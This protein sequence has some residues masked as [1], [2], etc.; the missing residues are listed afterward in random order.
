MPPCHG[1][2]EELAG[3]A[4][5]QQSCIFPVKRQLSQQS[6]AARTLRQAK[7]STETFTSLPAP[8]TPIQQVQRSRKP[9]GNDGNGSLANAL[10]WSR[11]QTIPLPEESGAKAARAKSR[12]LHGQR[13]KTQ[14][15]C[16]GASRGCSAGTATP[17]HSNPPRSAPGASPAAVSR[18]PLQGA[19]TRGWQSRIL[20]VQTLLPDPPASP[21][22][23]WCHSVTLVGEGGK[24]PR[25]DGTAGNARRPDPSSDTHSW[26]GHVLALLPHAVRED[27]APSFPL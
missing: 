20:P 25:C 18:E 27:N 6:I 26:C 23:V 4:H 11:C 2:G 9:P 19:L 1:S 24:A 14:E 8:N 15:L 3:L 16:A 22:A 10:G 5:H 12:L 17:S 21:L 7:S 13:G